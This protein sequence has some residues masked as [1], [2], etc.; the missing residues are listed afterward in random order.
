METGDGVKWL[1]P[2]IFHRFVRHFRKHFTRMEEHPLKEVL[3]DTLYFMYFRQRLVRDR[4][5]NSNNYLL[6]RFFMSC[7]YLH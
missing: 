5:L 2:V 6:S 4:I 7:L 3:F 1:F